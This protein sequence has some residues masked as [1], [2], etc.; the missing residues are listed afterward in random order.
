MIYA[1]SRNCFKLRG[2]LGD[3]TERLRRKLYTGVGG[4]TE[5]KITL[6]GY[7]IMFR[8]MINMDFEETRTEG[9]NLIAMRQ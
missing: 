4:V 9:F 3:K 2:Y 7:M 1:F 6:G 5:E 8:D